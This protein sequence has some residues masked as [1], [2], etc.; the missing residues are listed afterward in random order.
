MNNISELKSVLEGVTSK[1]CPTSINLHCHTICS[2]GSL[3]PAE[4]IKQ[5]ADKNVNHISVTDHHNIS[6]YPAMYDWLDQNRSC[7]KKLP[8]LWT[9]IEISCLLSRCLVHAIG[10]GFDLS[11]YSITPYICGEAPSGDYLQ[12]QNVVRSIHLAGGIVLLAH[13]ARY[14]LPFTQLINEAANIGFDGAEAWYDYQFSSHWRPTKLVC[15]SIDN[16]LKQLNLLSSCGTDTH[17]YSIFSR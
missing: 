2:D 8:N 7:Y 4:L 1:S 6:S 15:D 3:T 9:G 11:H 13:P 12:A 5:A 14:R 17:G 16:Q 10:L